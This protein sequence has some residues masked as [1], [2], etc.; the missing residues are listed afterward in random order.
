MLFRLYSSASQH[1]TLILLV[2][3]LYVVATVASPIPVEGQLGR[4]G[5]NNVFTNDIQLNLGVYNHTSQQWLKWEPHHTDNS[6]TITVAACVAQKLCVTV[7]VRTKGE[8]KVFRKPLGMFPLRATFQ[9][10]EY[11][12]RANNMPKESLTDDLTFLLAQLEPYNLNL[13]KTSIQEISDA[14]KAAREER[15]SKTYRIGLVNL[16]TKCWKKW[17]GMKDISN[18]LL[19]CLGSYCYMNRHPQ[20]VMMPFPLEGPALNS[21]DDYFRTLGLTVRDSQ[22]RDELLAKAQKKENLEAELGDSIATDMSFISAWVRLD[23]SKSIIEKWSAVQEDIFA[24]R[25]S[26]QAGLDNNKSVHDCPFFFGG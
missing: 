11:Q 19:I 23:G 8:E 13:L 26:H 5:D 3:A 12:K 17:T 2:V 1:S 6:G 18:T 10:D 15:E 21:E 4:R 14:R 16:K 22:A 24:A 7:D 20:I 9:R 25:I